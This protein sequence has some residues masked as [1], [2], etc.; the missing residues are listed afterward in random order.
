MS[1]NTNEGMLKSAR[2]AAEQQVDN[3][4]DQFAGKIPGGENYKQQA[5]D[6][7]DGIL[8]NLQKE[9]ENRIGGMGGPQGI[10]DRVLSFFRKK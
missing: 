1:D 10:F 5:K 9:G 6:A 3:A 7:A 4:I 2:D 8:D